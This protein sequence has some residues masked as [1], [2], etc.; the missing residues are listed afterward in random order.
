MKKFGKM[1]VL[2][3]CVMLLALLFT[4]CDSTTQQPTQGAD[5]TAGGTPTAAP[6]DQPTL[7][8]VYMKAG[9]TYRV[10]VWN[11]RETDEPFTQEGV[12]GQQLRE[13]ADEMKEKY[14]V[15]MMYI[16]APGNWLGDALDSTQAGAPICDILHCGG[17]WAMLLIYGYGGSP[18]DLMVPLNRYSEAGSFSDARYWDVDLQEIGTFNGNQYFFVPQG[19]GFNMVALNM[20]TFF[21][22]MLI[23]KGGYTEEQLYD[24]SDKGEWTFDR[25]REVA[26]NCT[27]LDQEIYGMSLGENSCALLC[28]ITA[29]GGDLVRKED[30]N[31]VMTE[32]FAANGAKTVEAIEYYV[33]MV[34]DDKSVYLGENPM[35]SSEATDFMANK[36]ALMPTYINRAEQIYEN[37]ESDYGILM[38][39]KGPSADRYLSDKNW[40]EP[41]CIL[42]NIPNVEGAVQAASIFL[43]PFMAVDDADN[44]ALLEAEAQKFRLDERSINTLK[45]IPEANSAKSY[46]VYLSLKAT[47]DADVSTVLI[48]HTMEFINGTDSPQTYFESM[49]QAVNS[50]LDAAL[51]V[52]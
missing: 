29:N 50:A 6:T 14:G 23:R 7:E 41:W 21:N 1:I 25:M 52:K 26:L 19:N 15:T 3:A 39:P 37:M 49:A 16:A 38:P 33:S 2:C 4:A 9:D 8:K 46:M 43:K 22:K 32:R 17:P 10:L 51:L 24:W 18:G 30:V 31:G 11:T 20:A 45:K 5:Q 35:F 44:L 42:N 48:Y 28:M 27:D 12:R 40:I 34:R 36:L 13:R 47:Q